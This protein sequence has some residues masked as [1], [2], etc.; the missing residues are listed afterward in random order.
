[1]PDKTPLILLP[2]L[3]LDAGLWAHQTE[4]LGDIADMTVADLTLDDSVGAMAKRVL[5]A[6][7]SRFALAGL[8]MGGYVAQEIMRRA[9]DRVI[10]LALLDTS[11][12]ADTPEQTERRLGLIEL[13]KKGKFKGV[14][15]RLLPMLVNEAHLDNAAITGPIMAMAEHVGQEGFARQQ[16][17]IMGRPDGTEDLER[18]QC[19]T[20]VLVGRDDALTPPDIMAEMA[21]RIPNATFVTIENAGHLPPLEQPEAVSAVLRYWLGA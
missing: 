6:A 13:S 14:T 7:P 9:P 2:G 21:S 8:S 19:S 1:M 20:L 12:K 10:K 16:A 15:Q 4:T 18:I 17:A 3:L 5:D 11:H